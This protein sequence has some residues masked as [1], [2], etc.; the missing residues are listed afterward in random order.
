MKLINRTILMTG[1]TSGISFA[2]AKR[3]L[4]MG[5]TVIITG[6][7]QERID[8]AVKNNPGLIGLVA[9]VSDPSS[10]EQLAKELAIYHPKLDIIFNNAGN[11]H[12]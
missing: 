5:N 8:Q 1:G 3:F 6:R 10:V 2:F 11:L 9:N 12:E 4:E 7:S